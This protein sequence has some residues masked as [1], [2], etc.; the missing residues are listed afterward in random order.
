MSLDMEGHI[1]DAFQSI[2]ATRYSQS[3]SRD[4]KGRWVSGVESGS[5]HKVNLQPLSDKEIANLGEGAERIQDFRKI[6][7]NDGD[8]YSLTPQDEWE[9]DAPDLA[10]IR[11]TVYAMDNRPWRN[12]CKCVVHRNDR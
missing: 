9:F 6:Y 8:L 11:F 10:G 3:G 12:Y 4:S 2:P 5:P 7:V 1:D